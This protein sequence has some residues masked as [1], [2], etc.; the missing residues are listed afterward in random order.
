MN[1]NFEADFGFNRFWATL[2]EWPK[3][4]LIQNQPQ[5]LRCA[6]QNEYNHQLLGLKSSN[7]QGE[8]TK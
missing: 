7:S 2:V 5:D 8:K 4:I 1:S 3:G 6:H